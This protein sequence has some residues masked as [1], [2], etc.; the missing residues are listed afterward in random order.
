MYVLLYSTFMSQ[1]PLPSNLLTDPLSEL[2]SALQLNLF[3]LD[4]ATTAVLVEECFPVT[5]EDRERIGIESVRSGQIG[6]GVTAK[7]KVGLQ[8]GEGSMVVVLDR[9]GYTVSHTGSW[10]VL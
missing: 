5:P 10:T 2:T 7:A 3:G 1:S 6:E 4:P 9:R 8:G